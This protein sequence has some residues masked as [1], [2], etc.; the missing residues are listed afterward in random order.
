MKTIAESP[1]AALERIQSGYSGSDE[2]VLVHFAECGIAPEDIAPR[3]NC[4]TFHAW[5]AKNR[6]VAKGAISCRVLTWIPQ[7]NKDGDT[8]DDK[9]KPKMRPK[10]AYVFHESQTVA[11]DAPK[12]TKPDGAD[13]P[14]LI[15]QQD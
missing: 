4:L 12:G 14:A 8:A 10:T 9:A 15:R 6:R 7:R 3:E 13:N 2:T 11:A 5:K 1:T